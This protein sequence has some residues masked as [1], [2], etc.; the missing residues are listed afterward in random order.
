MPDS[1][2]KFANGRTEAPPDCDHEHWTLG[3]PRCF[4]EMEG[5]ASG[6]VRAEDQQQAHEHTV[7]G[8]VLFGWHVITVLADMEFKLNE[9]AN[10]S[11]DLTRR[12][13]AL[14]TIKNI[15]NLSVYVARTCTDVKAM[16]AAITSAAELANAM[17]E[18]M[19]QEKTAPVKPVKPSNIVLTDVA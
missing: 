9:I 10:E 2:D 18:R 7:N 3:C 6:A 14:N 11:I 16:E 1:P 8:G 19:E 13:L 12:A 15:H 17:K 4:Y 5:L